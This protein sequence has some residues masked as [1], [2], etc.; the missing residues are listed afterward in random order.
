MTSDIALDSRLGYVDFDGKEADGEPVGPNAV[1]GRGG[2]APEPFGA[3]GTCAEFEHQAGP[4]QGWKA[5][6]LGGP[7]DSLVPATQPV[8]VLRVGRLAILGLPSEVTKQMGLRIRTAVEAASGGAYD[9]VVMSGLTNG[10]SSY[11]ATPEEYDACHYEGSFTLFGRRQGPLYRDIAVGVSEALLAGTPYVGDPEPPYRVA[12]GGSYPEPEP[13]P[14]AGTPVEQPEES[15]VRYGRAAFSWNGGHPAIDAPPGKRLV[16]TRRLG[17]AGKRWRRVAIDDGFFDILERDP[18]TDVWTTT[19]QT[20]D[21]MPLG[22]YKFV[23]RGRAD[24]GGGPEDYRIESDRFEVTPITAIAP[25]LTVTRRKARVTATYP[26]P[27]EEK[28]LLALPRRVRS[29]VAVLGVKKGRKKERRVRAKLTKD[30]LAFQ[31]RV[32][33]G[34]TV[35]VIRV[36]DACGN[37]SSG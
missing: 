32:P 31:A 18:E 35:R 15:V 12:T 29:G 14:D 28:T 23:I 2:V 33:R 19:F 16:T 1:L 8:T 11:T 3:D 4:G 7:G 36:K 9:E 17:R 26:E 13:T 34:A 30:R 37:S 21:C 6:A 5:L 20:T 25:V 22:T 27:D 24:K 10:Y